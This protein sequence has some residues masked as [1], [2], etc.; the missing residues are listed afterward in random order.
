MP[1]RPLKALSVM[2]F[3]LDGVFMYNNIIVAG[4]L[5]IYECRI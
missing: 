2:F 4:K 3:G 1:F 5:R